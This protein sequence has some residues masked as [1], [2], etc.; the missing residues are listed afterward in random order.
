LVKITQMLNRRER[1]G[2]A[3]VAKFLEEAIRGNQTAV[4]HEIRGKLIAAAER[5]VL[6]LD[7]AMDV[8]L[9]PSR[10]GVLGTPN[11]VNEVNEVK[12]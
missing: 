8:A 11:E 10:W 6:T 7:E 5:G 3:Q 1:A 12:N 2:A 9:P 4:V